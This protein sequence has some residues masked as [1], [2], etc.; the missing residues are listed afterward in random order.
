M[1]PNGVY[2]EDTTLISAPVFR[3]L[4]SLS[5]ED[6]ASVEWLRRYM[7]SKTMKI[8]CAC[9]YPEG[10]KIRMRIFPA[11]DALRLDRYSVTDVHASHCFTHGRAIRVRDPDAVARPSPAIF[12][13]FQEPRPSIGDTS[14]AAEMTAGSVTFDSYISTAVVQG[15]VKA[16]QHF[17]ADGYTQGSPTADYFVK[18]VVESLHAT[19]FSTGET[20]GTIA[21]KLGLRIITGVIQFEAEPLLRMDAEQLSISVPL[22]V[23]EA[24]AE[25]P[26]LR[27]EKFLVSV[28][29]LRHAFTSAKKY[30]SMTPPPYFFVAIASGSNLHRLWIRPAFFDRRFLALVE[31]ELE[32]KAFGVGLQAGEMLFKPLTLFHILLIAKET[33]SWS[34]LGVEEWSCRP[35]MVGNAPRR[36][37]E[38]AGVEFREE[39]Y[40]AEKG[41]AYGIDLEDRLHNL[42]AKFPQANFS[43]LTP[44][45]LVKPK[46]ISDEPIIE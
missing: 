40:L 19:L 26:K 43:V 6:A 11:E 8:Y 28:T 20:A 42:R 24:D 12:K 34:W 32:R 38:I 9:R 2:I 41:K 33:G 27:R 22:W 4:D 16:W 7:C 13:M 23:F 45:T 21:R 17:E 14:V 18:S 46:R 3:A 44:Q 31:S 25:I 37:I 15:E 29:L 30:S 10:T 35:D 5:I 39:T 36:F 1:T